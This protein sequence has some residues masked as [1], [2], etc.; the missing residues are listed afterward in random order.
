MCYQNFNRFHVVTITL[1]PTPIKQLN[2]TK[3]WEMQQNI[4]LQKIWTEKFGRNYKD[5]ACSSTIANF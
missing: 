2:M 4:K 3:N 5:L 1:Q